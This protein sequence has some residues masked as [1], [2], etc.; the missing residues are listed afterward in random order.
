MQINKH[1]SFYVRNGWP[2]KIINA[3]ND[4]NLIFS[5]NNELEAV[6]TIGVGRVMI[7]AMRYWAL[8]MGLSKEEKTPQGVL[9]ELTDLG[10]EIATQD[11]YCQDKGTLWLLHR[12]LAINDDQATAWYWAF[13][14][15]G[16]K[17]FNKDDF[18]TAFYS[19]VQRMSGNYQKAA[20][21]KEFD[22]FKNTYVSEKAFDINK[23]IE[24]DTVPFFAPLGLLTYGNGMFERAKITSKD[25][26]T[27]ILL[28]CLL[29]DNAELL[30]SKHQLSIDM[31]LEE[32]KQ[33]GKYLNLSYA[34]L[35][36]LLQ[37]LENQG[38]INVINNFG[39]RHVDITTSCAPIDI[40]KKH[41][42]A[43]ER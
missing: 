37:K 7:K 34:S 39:N 33:V 32:E 9:C 29:S 40:L 36:E 2:T 4:N 6:D 23:I 27:D 35:L 43:N 11:A 41:Y 42:H 22:C 10:K 17:S 18:C 38:F 19:Y 21:E 8:A 3:I 25:I 5:P 31:L 26:D 14:Q 13:N 24:E 12:N 28:Y 20:I 16:S 30:K 1:G 15:Y